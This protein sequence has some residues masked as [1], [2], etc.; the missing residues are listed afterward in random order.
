[1]LDNDMDISVSSGY[2][3]YVWAVSLYRFGLKVFGLWPNN[4]NSAKRNL[5]TELQIGS[6]LFL[7]IFVTNVPMVHATIRVGGD[8]VLVISS[9]QMTIPLLIIT[10]KYI[11]MQ[12][13]RS[14][15]SSV[16]NMMAEDWMALKSDTERRVMIRRARTARLIMTM[17]YILAMVGCVVL[18][19]PPYF[20]SEPVQTTNFMNRSKSL[21]LET[22]TFYDTDKSPQFELTYLLHAITTL[23]GGIIETCIDLFLVLIVLHVS[24]QLEIFRYRLIRLI[25]CE[26][27]NEALSDIVR[28][29]LRLIRFVDTIESMYSLVMLI[30]LLYFGVTFCLNGFLCTIILTDIESDG[31]V[32]QALYSSV[33]TIFLLMNTFL[34]CFAGEIITEQ[35]DAVFRAMYDLEWYNLESKNAR[36][37][38]LLM[39]RASRCLHITAGKVIPLT[40]TTY[41]SVLKTSCGY[42]SVLLAKR[43]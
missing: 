32:V 29:H 31:A 16:V 13:K 4:D 25:S 23:I 6:I 1:M 12:G 36:N 28:K 9:L 26:N 5:W 35:S 7:L 21:P 15:I 41:C 11:I 33:A 18:L 27:F 10:I 22:Y 38:I 43:D 8:I 3:D 40:M 34:F 42:I 24:G 30:L 20:G 39:I 37:L 17:G 14:D 19:V 2:K